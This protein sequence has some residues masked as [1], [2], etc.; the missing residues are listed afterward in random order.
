MG[1]FEFDLLS[2]AFSSNWIAPY[3]PFIKEFE[4]EFA[5]KFGFST[6]VA[7]SSG[8]AGLHLAARLLGI[9]QGDLV[10][11]PTLTFIASIS[12]FLYEG[13]EPIFV[14]SEKR[15]WN[16]DPNLLDEEIKF[17]VSNGKR[18]KAVIVVDLFGQ[19][20]D[21]DPILEVCNDFEIPIIEDAAE[22]L[23]ASYK[24][25][26]V[27]QF[28]KIG[29]FSFN[30]NKI[31]TTSGGGM[32]VA[33]DLGLTDR[34]RFLANQARDEAP[35]YQ[36]SEIGYNYRLSNLLAAIGVGQLRVLED[37]IAA[38]RSNFDFY[39]ANLADLPGLDFMPE[40]DFGISTHWL[41]CILIDPDGFG[42]TREEVTQA[43]E[44]DNIE[45]RPI[46]KPMHLQP[47]FKD[48][49]Q[50]GGAVSERLFDR[51]LCLPSGSNLSEME[52][53]RIV[54]IIKSKCANAS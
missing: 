9:K 46:W 11:C 48:C 36:H 49:G 37:R 21:W 16:I 29:V 28:G 24:G 44:A 3:G 35:H 41:T 51:G 6:A 32:L 2:R 53:N 1:D 12:P 47:V 54:E 25:K 27:G 42:A 22:A 26:P 17:C 19:S 50:R 18:P 10:I 43:L 15:S 39:S 40:A 14:D 7:T 33:D 45:S 23:G 13:A 5:R 30:G 4:R 20:A 8:T 34:A 38:R 52:L 31:I